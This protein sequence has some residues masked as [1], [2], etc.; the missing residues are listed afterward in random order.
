MADSSSVSEGRAYRHTRYAVTIMFVMVMVGLALVIYSIMEFR[1]TDCASSLQAREV[2]R[3]R[4]IGVFT[5][6]ANELRAD[7]EVRESFLAFIDNQYDE[8]PKPASC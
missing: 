7:D 1:R 8:M 5:R 3:E 6:L 2:A 4:D